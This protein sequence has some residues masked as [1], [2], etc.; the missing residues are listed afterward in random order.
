MAP[1]PPSDDAGTL[2][3]DGAAPTDAGIE[4][5]DAA[6]SPDGAPADQD[7][8]PLPDGLQGNATVDGGA[9]GACPRGGSDRNGREPERPLSPD[10]SPPE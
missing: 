5:A 6:R 4:P 8:A 10:A 3:Q 9:P 2:P 1:P 7:A